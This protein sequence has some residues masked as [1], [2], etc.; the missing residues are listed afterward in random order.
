MKLIIGLGNPESRYE[1]TRHNTGFFVLDALA[2]SYGAA[3]KHSVKFK[4]DIAELS[5]SGQKVLLVK[6]TTYY[7]LVGESAHT[8]LD[9]Y[10]LSASDVLIV[11]DELALPFGTLRVRAGGSDAGNNGVKSLNAHLGPDTLRL[12][13][14]IWS[15]LRDRMDDAD[16]VLAKFSAT[17]RM[18]LESI[19][20]Q[21]TKQIEQFVAGTLEPHTLRM[22]MK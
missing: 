22:E 2:R 1:G 12:R 6:P 4:A 7:N 10:K 9:F 16:F 18:Q 21:V 20:E 15:D 13:I 8:A 19:T 14:G 3:F 17:E 5:I 11:H